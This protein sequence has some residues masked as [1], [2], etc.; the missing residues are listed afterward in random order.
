MFLNIMLSFHYILS[1][2]VSMQIL[3][4]LIY[5]MLM[6]QL[7]LIDIKLSLYYLNIYNLYYLNKIKRIV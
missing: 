4:T 6:T 7:K 1:S 5:S 2:V 3:M